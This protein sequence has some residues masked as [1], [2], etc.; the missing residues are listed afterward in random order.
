MDLD[1]HSPVP[2]YYQLAETIREQVR[3]GEL[4]PGDQLLPERVLAEQAGISRMTARQALAYLVREGTLVV[5]HGLGTF[6]AEPKLTYDAFHLLGFSEEIMHH[7]E[8]ASSRL[9]ERALLV[10]PL[11]VAA[12]LQLAADEQAVKIVRL[13]RAGDA[14]LL[15]ETIYLPAALFPG[16]EAADL[17][18]GSL[19][20]LLESRYGVRMQRAE[21]ALEATIANDFESRLFNIDTGTPMILL[22]GITYDDRGRPAEY[23]KAV[24]RGDRF[25][26]A[27]ASERGV[28][29]P[30]NSVVRPAG[31]GLPAS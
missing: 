9:I 16:L 20:A 15:L 27:F 3:A 6:V 18:A 28:V 25:K 1:R 29:M 17:V 11:R 19:Y 31:N 2:L 13:R 26:F 21:Q 14:P 22:E 23:F 7:G 12:G 10:P 5:R 4:R 8:R 30:L 24:Y